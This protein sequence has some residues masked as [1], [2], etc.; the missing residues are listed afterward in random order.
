MIDEWTGKFWMDMVT[1]LL[2]NAGIP[3]GTYGLGYHQGV[4][5]IY[6]KD[7]GGDRAACIYTVDLLDEI[8]PQLKADLL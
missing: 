2:Q 8:I 1:V 6:W 7:K 4:P 5:T 3:S